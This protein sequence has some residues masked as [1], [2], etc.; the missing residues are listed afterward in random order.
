M[1]IKQVIGDYELFVKDL[2]A[3]QSEAGIDTSGCQLDHL[4][5]RVS[6]MDEYND[7]KAKLKPLSSTLATTI[8]NGREFS[9]FKLK[10]PLIVG[11]QQISLI[12][13]PTPAS[14][15]PYATGLEHAEVVITEGFKEFCELH[16]DTFTHQP[17]MGS[18]NATAILTFADKTTIKFH[19]IS[20]AEA[21]VLQ[22]DRFEPVR[23]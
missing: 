15:K 3:N 20:L 14:D 23:H 1:D 8:H 2:L 18:A 21:I 5:Y 4:C 12:E 13:L 6:S 19:P 11:N 17:D 16:K 9:I 10:Q 7:A 22:G